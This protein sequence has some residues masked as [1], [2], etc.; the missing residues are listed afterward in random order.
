MTES[1]GYRPVPVAPDPERDK[2]V[3]FRR[4]EDARRAGLA[5]DRLLGECDGLGCRCCNN[6]ERLARLAQSEL[7]HNGHYGVPACT[8][9][10]HPAYDAECPR[11]GV[12]G[13]AE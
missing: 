9:G 4:A 10:P 8:C 2:R 1:E 11:C 7:H 12:H 6:L 5:L 13:R 3:A